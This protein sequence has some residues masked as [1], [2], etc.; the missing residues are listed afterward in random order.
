MMQFIAFRPPRTLETSRYIR[1][2]AT[3]LRGGSIRRRQIAPVG[4]H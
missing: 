3:A 1:W 4:W 2:T